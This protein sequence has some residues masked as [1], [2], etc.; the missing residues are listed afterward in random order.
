M[1]ATNQADLQL[2]RLINNLVAM[3]YHAIGNAYNHWHG[4]GALD[5]ALIRMELHSG[6]TRSLYEARAIKGQVGFEPSDN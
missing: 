4:E 5:Q 3:D 1:H 2:M 6:S